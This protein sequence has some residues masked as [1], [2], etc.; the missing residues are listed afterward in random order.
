V[1]TPTT[2]GVVN[3]LCAVQLNLVGCGFY[4]NEVTTI[5]QGFQTETGIPLQ[6]PGKTVTTAATLT[7]DTN[8]DGTAEAVIVLTSV[9]PVNCN[10]VRATIPVLASRPGTGFADACCGGVATI[11][12]TTTFTVGDNN[13]FG[14]FTRTASCTLALGTRAPVVFSVTPSDGNCALPVQDLLISG[15]C[16][17]FTQAVPGGNPI[18]GT[19][20]SVIFQDKANPANT[21]T[22]GLNPSTSGQL[23]PLTCQLLDVEV[24]FTSANAGKTFLV[25]VVGTGGTSRNL[26]AAVTGQPAGCPLGN[27]Q[28]VQVTFTC[29]SSTTPVPGPTPDIAVVTSCKLDRQATGQ[30][31]LDVTGEKIKEGAI[32]TVGGVTPKKIK[33]VEVAPGTTNPTKLRLIKKVCNGLPGNVIITNPGAPASQPFNCTERCP[34][35]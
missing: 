27:E 1:T 35:Q 18:V 15:A 13:V 2:T 3:A 9:T 7:C 19:V 10:L 17:C 8:G 30:F 23:K 31:F 20:T 29:S 16:F 34:G 5:C 21:I 6:R 14:A 12:L 11:N 22:V 25:F 33:V 28:G 4:P 26:A 24:N 32:A